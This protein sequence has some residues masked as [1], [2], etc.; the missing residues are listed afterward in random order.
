V[1]QH[2]EQSNDPQRPLR[3]FDGC[4]LKLRCHDW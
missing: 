4:V 1:D 2:D 3:K